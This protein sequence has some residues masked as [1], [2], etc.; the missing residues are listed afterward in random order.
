MPKYI[1]ADELLKEEIEAYM[2]AQTKITAVEAY[3][4]NHLI[5]AKVQQLLCALPP[6]MLRRCGMGAGSERAT[7]TPT[8]N[9]FTMCGTAPS[10][11]T[12]LMTGRMILNSYRNTAP[13]AGQRWMEPMKIKL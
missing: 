10:A 1:D 13:S 11:I 6:P 3:L 9:W 4:L 7:A 8:V 5:H 2:N 12:A